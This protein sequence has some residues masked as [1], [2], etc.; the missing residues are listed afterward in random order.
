MI[1]AMTDG[2]V[3][4]ALECCFF[5]AQKYVPHEGILVLLAGD[6]RDDVPHNW[7]CLSCCITVFVILDD[8]FFLFLT[9][10]CISLAF[11][12]V[13]IGV[14]MHHQRESETS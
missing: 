10:S 1:R 5:C 6:K 11:D 7:M 12:R 8:W 14:L 3:G 13:S 9:Q 4:S 2:L